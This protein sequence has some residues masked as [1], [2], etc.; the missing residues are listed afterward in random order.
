MFDAKID[1]VIDF[2]LGGETAD[3]KTK[4]GMGHVLRNAQRAKHIGRFKR[5]TRASAAGGTRDFLQRHQQALA[6]HV[7]EG[8]IEVAVI[9]S[10]QVSVEHHLGDFLGDAFVEAIEKIFYPLIFL[11]HFLHSDFA[12]LAQADNQRWRKGAAPQ[13]SFLPTSADDRRKS[14]TWFTP[15]VQGADALGPVNLV[16]A[17]R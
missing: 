9:P 7:G 14:D 2:G 16:P 8:D 10:L 15:D 17:Y 1:S 12:C 6:F 11:W 5:S 13:A 4:T 3:T